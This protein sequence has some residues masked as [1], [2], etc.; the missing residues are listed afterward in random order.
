MLKELAGICTELS[1]FVALISLGVRKLAMKR[2]TEW[3]TSMISAYS[4]R[5]PIAC[6]SLCSITTRTVPPFRL[7]PAFHS[8]SCLQHVG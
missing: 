3:L 5:D 4:W 1:G 2:T 7:V 6:I 8:Y